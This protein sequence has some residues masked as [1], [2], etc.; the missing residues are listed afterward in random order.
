[1]ELSLDLSLS[2]A[3]NTISLFLGDVF[4]STETSEKLAMLEDFL[5][6]LENEMRKIEAFKRELPL[7]MLLVNDGQCLLHE[8]FLQTTVFFCLL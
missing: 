8:F 7:C 5:K 6:R 1:M 4:R 2:F 3:P